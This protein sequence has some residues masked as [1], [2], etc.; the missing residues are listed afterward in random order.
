MYDSTTAVPVTET[1]IPLT[2]TAFPLPGGCPWCSGPFTTVYHD[3]LC[4]RLKAIEYYPNGSPK[5]VELFETTKRRL[6]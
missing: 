4:P 1:R 2:G 6:P 5:R 3:G